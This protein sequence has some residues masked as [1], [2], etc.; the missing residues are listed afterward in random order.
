[1]AVIYKPATVKE[2]YER[3]RHVREIHEQ[4]DAI[5]DPDEASA[6]HERH[7]DD[8]KA[9]VEPPPINMLI[10]DEFMQ[11]HERFTAHLASALLEFGKCPEDELP[12]NA[13]TLWRQIVKGVER[14]ADRLTAPPEK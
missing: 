3:L 2:Y 12:T 4:Y 13:I 14:I 6:F 8:L 10:L 11:S 9:Y 5:T 1:M 7:W